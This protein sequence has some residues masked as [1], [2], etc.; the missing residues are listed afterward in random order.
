MKHY[1]KV[2]IIA[3]STI[4]ISCQSSQREDEL[5]HYLKTNWTTPEN[6]VIKKFE[7]HDYVFIGEHHR[8]K[9]DLDLIQKLIPKLYENGIN[10]LAIEF[11]NFQDQ[12]L[13][14]SLL[15]LPHFDRDLAKKI[16]FKWYPEW[17]YEEYIDIYKVAWEANH[18][19]TSNN[20]NKFRVVNLDRL[21]HPCKDKE[22]KSRDV[23]M[24][25]VIFKEIVS[26][27]Q[28][29]LIYSGSHHAFTKY[30]QPI[31]NLEKDSL[32]GFRNRMGNIIYDSLKEKT[33][34]IYLHAAWLADKGFDKGFDKLFILPVNGVID[35]TMK[36]FKNKQVGFDVINTPFGKLTSNNSYYAL[37]YANFTLDQYCDGYIYQNEFKN[38]QSITMEDNFITNDNIN[39]LKAYFS[40]TNKSKKWIDSLNVD[41]ANEML[42]VVD[43]R[44]HFKH[45]MN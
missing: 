37:G 9:H 36:Y 27:K 29:A 34:H 33:F 3:V 5:V 32:V 12:Y 13:V 19:N 8:I 31:Y 41:N 15:A 23:F 20:K 16:F 11:G 14:D 40:C 4:I 42:M 2:V 44:S 35:S 43:I 39:E 26:K 18:L 25:N 30:R 1:L 45:L 38:Y 22:G 28:K 10:I 7:N 24:A 6:Y 21:P 17:G